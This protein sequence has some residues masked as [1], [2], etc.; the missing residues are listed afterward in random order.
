MFSHN[1]KTNISNLKIDAIF[2]LLTT[3]NN[4]NMKLDFLPDLTIHNILEFIYGK[5]PLYFNWSDY[6]NWGKKNSYV[7]TELETKHFPCYYW[8]GSI[9][10]VRYNDDETPIYN[11]QVYSPQQEHVKNNTN[12]VTSVY[13]YLDE[14]FRNEDIRSLLI[15]HMN[16]YVPVGSIWS[17]CSP[18]D[19]QHDEE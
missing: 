2:L 8:A 14:G 17:T 3:I 15:R 9:S 19:Y 10:Y 13:T 16:K 6:W 5:K 1:F 11:V 18:Y 7:M 4:K 12:V